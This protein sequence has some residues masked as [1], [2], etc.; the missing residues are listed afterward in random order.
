MHILRRRRASN[1]PLPPIF[2]NNTVYLCDL[3]LF[4][5][6]DIASTENVRNV[7]YSGLCQL[8]VD[9]VLV[10]Q[11]LHSKHPPAV[12]QEHH[13][14]RRQAVR[15]ICSCGAAYERPRDVEWLL[16]NQVLRAK[17]RRSGNLLRIGVQAAG[18][19]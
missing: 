8:V 2:L 11:V 16:D 14:L 13:L 19:E 18:R 9:A 5:R 10:R 12:L 3:R 1:S 4:V 7:L 17:D 6:N 15:Q